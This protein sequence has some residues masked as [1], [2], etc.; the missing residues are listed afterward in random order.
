[1]ELVIKNPSVNAGE[2]RDVESI[3]GP[4]RSPE[5][6]HS[7]LLQYSCLENLMDRGFLWATV[8]RISRSQTLLK[9]LSTHI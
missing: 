6:G 4:R 5:E 9:Q 8:H 1:M 3:P 2:V 7:I